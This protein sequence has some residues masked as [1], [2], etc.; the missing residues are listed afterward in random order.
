MELL[1][2][3]T[4]QLKGLPTRAAVPEAVNDIDKPFLAITS[5]VGCR[6]GV[7]TIAAAVPSVPLVTGRLV[8]RFGLWMGCEGGPNDGLRAWLKSTWVV[9]SML[10]TG[11]H[12]SVE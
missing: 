6:L 1:T 4:F 3:N 5:D 11:R 7:F 12:S 10:I 9:Q 2:T 8:G